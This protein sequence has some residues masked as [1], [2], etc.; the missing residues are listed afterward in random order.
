MAQELLTTFQDD[1]GELAL[2]PGTGGVFEVR[3]KGSSF[4]R[5][6]SQGASRISRNSSRWS[7]T[8]SPLARTWVTP[9]ADL[10]SRCAEIIGRC[11]MGEFVKVARA[12]EIAPGEARAVEA[13][14]KRIALF[15]VDGTFHAIDDTC[16]HRGDPPAWT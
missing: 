7:E 2:I 4:G 15:N 10:T 11:V 6:K 12:D 3:A 14:G 8:T 13:G 1:I 9:I 5:A 16:T